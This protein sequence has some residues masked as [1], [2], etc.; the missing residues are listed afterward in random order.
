VNTARAGVVNKA[1]LVGA[2]RD[3]SIAGAA[4]DVH[5][6]APCAPDDPLVL[7]DNVLA[8]PWTSA[9]TQEASERTLV[10]AVDEVIA[11]LRGRPP[12]HPL[13]QI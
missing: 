3:G 6:P 4:I 12:R 8:T 1:D 11:V 2:L 5:D 10:S 13:N 9:N 7:L